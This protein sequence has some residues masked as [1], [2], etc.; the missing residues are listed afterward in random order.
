MYYSSGEEFGEIVVVVVVVVLS[1][2]RYPYLPIANSSVV[3]DGVFVFTRTQSC[4]QLKHRQHFPSI[5]SFSVGR[6]CL[7]LTIFNIFK[8]GRTRLIE[9]IVKYNIF[10]IPHIE[11]AQSL[12]DVYRLSCL[13]TKHP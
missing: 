12:K 2:V 3:S 11:Y 10:F 7:G 1:I 5:H 6:V 8:V 9:K 13:F 4:L